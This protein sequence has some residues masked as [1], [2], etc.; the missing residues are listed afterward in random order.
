ASGMRNMMVVKPLSK[1]LE[2]M[3]DSLHHHFINDLP[4]W[5]D[6]YLPEISSDLITVASNENN[7]RI[8]NGQSG[9]YG[10]YSY[11][12]LRIQRFIHAELTYDK[13]YPSLCR[14]FTHHPAA[15]YPVT[16]A[17]LT[18]APNWTLLAD[19]FQLKGRRHV[20]ASIKT[21]LIQLTMD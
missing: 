21:E 5:A 19:R 7:K 13:I 3:S 4:Y 6:R 20:I 1:L 9:I 16:Q 18:L 15:D 8:V 10:L 2:Q 14:F 12:C 11:D 17:S